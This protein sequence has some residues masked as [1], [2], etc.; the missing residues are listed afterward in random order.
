MTDLVAQIDDRVKRN[1]QFLLGLCGVDHIVQ[2]R[3]GVDDFNATKKFRCPNPHHQILVLQQWRSDLGQG[4]GLIA[5]VS[6]DF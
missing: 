4:L 3:H 6:A 2:C 5:K 1:H